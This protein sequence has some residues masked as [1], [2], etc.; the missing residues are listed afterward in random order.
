M[1]GSALGWYAGAV[2]PRTGH[3]SASLGHDGSRLPADFQGEILE[4]GRSDREATAGLLA[5]AF[6]DSPLNRAVIGEGPSRRLRCNLHGMRALLQSA[7]DSARTLGAS[8]LRTGERTLQAALLA[9][10]P[11]EY[12]LPM[13]SWGQQVRCLLGQGVRV[14]SRWG[15]VHRA[16]EAVHPREPHW[17]L[18]VLGVDPPVQGQGIG[19]GLLAHWLAEVDRA[20]GFAYLETDRPEN[21]PFYERA[22]FSVLDEITVLGVR[23]WCMARV[24]RNAENA[25]VLD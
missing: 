10:G 21:R 20:A 2:G 24:S 1:L 9:T 18:N 13:P 17:Y 7:E 5:R 23:V 3:Q 22:G 12:P 4:L 6:R 11:G 19:S 16:L 25:H 8:S 15:E 14:A